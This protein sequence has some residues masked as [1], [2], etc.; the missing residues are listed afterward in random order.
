MDKKWLKN[1]IA[2]AA[3]TI[4]PANADEIQN[5]PPTT[6]EQMN[7]FD[8]ILNKSNNYEEFKNNL[9]NNLKNSNIR[10]DIIFT[11]LGA[12][13]NNNYNKEW[14]KTGVYK[15]TSMDYVLDAAKGE[16]SGLICGN[17]AVAFEKI[18]NDIGIKD[19]HIFFSTLNGGNHVLFSYKN[20]DGKWNIINWG[21][22]YKGT[23]SLSETISLYEE[24]NGVMPFELGIKDR[25]TIK[26][27]AQ[28]Q[29]NEITNTNVEK[30]F[31]GENKDNEIIFTPQ[32]KQIT[33]NLNKHWIFNY[34]FKKNNDKFNSLNSV[35]YSEIEYKNNFNI[36]GIENDFEIG[37]GNLKLDIGDNLLT[38]HL[39]GRFI[40]DSKY[41]LN[42]KE[43]KKLHITL[44]NSLNGAISY[45]HSYNN[46]KVNKNIFEKISGEVNGIVGVNFAFDFKTGELHLLAGKKYSLTAISP[47]IQK[48]AIDF[49][50]GY[51]AEIGYKYNE[52]VISLGSFKLSSISARFN[53]TK[54]S[55]QYSIN[56]EWTQN[57]NSKLI[58]TLSYKDVDKKF[59]GDEFKAS[60]TYTKNKGTSLSVF[61]SKIN[62]HEK[63][64]FNI[65]TV[66]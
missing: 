6:I 53:S 18:A 34:Q 32:E 44:K 57:N 22:I 46:Q 65:N 27:H 30:N 17:A 28:N 19:T 16:N 64:G 9:K 62:G 49:N 40:L 36:A 60:L 55:K 25:P 10:P 42:Q 51:I 54:H 21:E 59:G 58:T 4:S 66:F 45:L 35:E 56:T 47:E 3:L 63:F 5:I 41:K 52:P 31:L 37:V 24:K 26:S 61:A 8:N 39:V 7:N 48:G 50:K 2:A 13:L 33:L 23:N 38:E 14:E 11:E 12:R 43:W 20:K 29:I 1:L 15:K